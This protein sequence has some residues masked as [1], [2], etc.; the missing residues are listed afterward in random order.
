MKAAPTEPRVHLELS[1][2]RAA[3]LE[4]LLLDAVAASADEVHDIAVVAGMLRQ[5]LRRARRRPSKDP[6]KAER[7]RRERVEYAVVRLAFAAI[8]AWLVARD[9]G[10]ELEAELGEVL[11]EVYILCQAAGDAVRRPV[12]RVIDGGRVR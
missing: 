11:D 10:D 2:A 5:Q 6:V 8:H 7:Q 3:L 1:V 9:H 12:L 4:R